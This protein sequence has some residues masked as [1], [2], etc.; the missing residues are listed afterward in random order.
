MDAD[1]IVKGNT[2]KIKFTSD[3]TVDI[4]PYVIIAH[5]IRGKRFCEVTFG[6]GDRIL[7]E[8]YPLSRKGYR[9]FKVYAL[10]EDINILFQ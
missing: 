4:P 8:C 2:K 6:G 9:C 7:D 1:I 5:T 10:E 3:N